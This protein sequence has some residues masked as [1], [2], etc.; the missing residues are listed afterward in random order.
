M[1]LEKRI[2]DEHINTS[3]NP[4][5]ESFA[6]EPL[7]R[8]EIHLRNRSGDFWYF[9]LKVSTSALLRYPFFLLLFGLGICWGVNATILFLRL[10]GN[11]PAISIVAVLIGLPIFM[12][13]YWLLL[14]TSLTWIYD[15]A[16]SSK[17]NKALKILIA[18]LVSLTIY[19]SANVLFLYIWAN[20]LG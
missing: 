2:N 10:S 17:P 14:N 20:L 8:K 5:T 19:I 18:L 3:I 15:I 9:W 7:R 13:P 1:R 4:L 12:F 11:N 16:K 6:K